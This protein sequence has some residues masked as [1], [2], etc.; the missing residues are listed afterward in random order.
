[1]CWKWWRRGSW[2][3][4]H[5]RLGHMQTVSFLLH[6]CCLDKPF[7]S[8]PVDDGCLL[9]IF[10]QVFFCLF[11]YL[12]RFQSSCS[13]LSSW[14]WHPSRKNVLDAGGCTILQPYVYSASF[15]S[16]VLSHLWTVPRSATESQKVLTHSTCYDAEFTCALLVNTQ[17]C[18]WTSLLMDTSF[19]FCFCLIPITLPAG[20]VVLSHCPR[21]MSHEAVDWSSP[22]KSSE[23]LKTEL[24]KP[25]CGLSC[26]CC[27]F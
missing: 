21:R 5:P 4:R 11:F 15:T 9:G 10:T 20:W 26:C 12:S 7:L 16:R 23:W 18:S 22:L 14:E 1:M 2:F 13:Q 3:A 17:V 25:P 6:Y 24:V 19:L 27:F 8:S